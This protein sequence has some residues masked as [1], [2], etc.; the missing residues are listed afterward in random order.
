MASICRSPPDNVPAAFV[1]RGASGGNSSSTSPIAAARSAR[2]VRHSAPRRRFSSTVSSGITPP[3]SGTCATPR[4]AI[5]SVGSAVMS[6]PKAVIVPALARTS[7]LIV[8]SSVVL[9]APLAPRMAVML[10]SSTVSVTSDSA[11]T[12]P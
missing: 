1:R 5:R 4:R 6:S 2:S 7:P 11:R 3:P 9:P 12:S 8:R 10:P